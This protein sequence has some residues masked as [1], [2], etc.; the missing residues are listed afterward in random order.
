MAV[1]LPTPSQLLDI[2]GDVGLDLTDADVTSFIELMRPSVSAY[3]VVDAMP[4]VLPAVRYLRT[5]GY[6]PVGEE[7]SHI[8]LY[9]KTTV[10]GAPARP[11]TWRAKPW[12]SRTISCWPACP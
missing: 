6:R 8:A 1:Q 12:R 5:P 9:V 2:A 7:N 4:D 10:Q 11:A 3:N